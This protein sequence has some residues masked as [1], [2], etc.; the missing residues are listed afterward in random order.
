MTPSHD[1][2]HGVAAITRNP[3]IF[4]TAPHDALSSRQLPKLDVAGSIPV[5]RSN[6]TGGYS[7]RC[8]PP[9]R[10]LPKCCLALSDGA[11]SWARE[12]AAARGE[13]EL[14][15][16]E[17]TDC[18][19]SAPQEEQ[20]PEIHPYGPPLW[21]M[22]LRYGADPTIRDREGRSPVDMVANRRDRT[23]FTLFSQRREG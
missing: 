6:L 1:A 23:Y 13:R 4:L 15:E 16:L 3:S 14:P 9:P 21:H 5:A 10:L 20:R 18:A 7:T 17:R 11:G 8:S 19:A 12:A 22:V 2:S